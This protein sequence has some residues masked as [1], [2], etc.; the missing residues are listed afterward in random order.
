MRGAAAAGSNQEA[1]PRIAAPWSPASRTGLYPNCRCKRTGRPQIASKAPRGPGLPCSAAS[2]SE[3]GTV[4]NAETPGS[5]PDADLEAP[6]A[7]LVRLR[8]VL[9]RVRLWLA[10]RWTPLCLLGAVSLLSLGARIWRLDDP[11][12]S[13][14]G[15]G[16]LIFDEKYYVNAARVLLNLHVSCH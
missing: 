6:S 12:D 13:S 11:L 16:A 1:R 2:T 8:S 7:A 9:D 15:N 5:A 4:Q 14:T 3:Q 10:W